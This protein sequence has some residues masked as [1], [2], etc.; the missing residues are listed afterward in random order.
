MLFRSSEGLRAIPDGFMLNMMQAGIY[1]VDGDI[2]AA[3]AVYEKLLESRPNSEIVVN[4]LA[5]LIAENAENEVELQGAYRSEERR[6][7]KE[8]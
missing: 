7:V 5:S 3:I 6:V 8:G 4:N 2:S 1:E